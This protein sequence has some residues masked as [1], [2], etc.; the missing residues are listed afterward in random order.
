MKKLITL[1]A[2]CLIALA[3]LAFARQPRPVQWEYSET[4]DF[5]KANHLGAEGWEM[6]AVVEGKALRTFYFK[7]P[8]Q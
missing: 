2:L 4:K 8:R 7:R 6:I 5:G 3:S 1:A